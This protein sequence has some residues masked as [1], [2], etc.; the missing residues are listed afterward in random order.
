MKIVCKQ[1]TMIEDDNQYSQVMAITSIDEEDKFKHKEFKFSGEETFPLQSNISD[2]IEILLLDE[3]NKRIVLSN[4]LPTVVTLNAKVMTNDEFHIRFS[5]DNSKYK[6]NTPTN[7]KYLMNAPA[8]L[9]EEYHVALLSTNFKNEFLPDKS[10]DF[11][12]IY[13]LYDENGIAS[14]KKKIS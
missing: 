3:N 6:S 1:I 11:Y 4:S 10:I 7:F 2:H 9:S 14:D 5:S 8:D 12:F 13:N